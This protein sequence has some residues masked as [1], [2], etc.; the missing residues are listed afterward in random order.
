MEEKTHLVYVGP[1]VREVKFGFCLMPSD[2]ESFKAGMS[3]SFHIVGHI[4]FDLVCAR[5]VKLFF[6]SA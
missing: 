6:L 1:P 4:H 2:L 5:P 3:N